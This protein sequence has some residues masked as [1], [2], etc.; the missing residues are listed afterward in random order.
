MT[1]LLS[2]L[3]AHFASVTFR[4]GVFAPALVLSLG[5][6]YP[7]SVAI[8]TFP[9]QKIQALLHITLFIVKLTQQLFLVK[10]HQTQ[11]AIAA[12]PSTHPATP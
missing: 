3:T 11:A 2:R 6:P 1:L 7:K 12:Q 4:T 10:S 8:S 5:A 9:L